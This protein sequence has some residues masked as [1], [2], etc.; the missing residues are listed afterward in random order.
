M[1]NKRKRVAVFDV[2]GTLLKGDSLII[3]AKRSQNIARQILGFL[4]FI[5]WIIFWQ[6][7]FVST[8]KIKT[9]FLQSFGICEAANKAEEYGNFNWLL[10]DMR[11]NCRP[12]ALQ[13]L[14]WHQERGDKVLL[15]SASP[16]VLLQ[17][18]ADW[19]GVEVICTELVRSKGKWLPK[20]SSPNC[21]G[22]EKVNRL[23]QH[24]GELGNYE[25]EAY[26]DSRGDRELLEVANLPHYRNFISKPL[27]YLGSSFVNSLFK[28]FS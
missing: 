18:F 24:L 22:L 3:A 25:I 19:L 4:I 5:P 20:L 6:L 13:R 28:F 9:K 12:V 14:R 7:K 11:S 21:K 23:T 8:E 27:P 16:R 26:G 17:G 10:N 2:D 1:I 15:C